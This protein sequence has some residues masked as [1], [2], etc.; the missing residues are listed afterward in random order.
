M[1]D[2]FVQALLYIDP[3]NICHWILVDPHT[4]KICDGCN[5]QCVGAHQGR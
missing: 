5:F 3:T 1:N 4:F 2:R